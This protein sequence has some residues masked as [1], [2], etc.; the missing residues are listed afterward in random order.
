MRSACGPLHGKT[1]DRL[2]DHYLR[3]FNAGAQQ[4]TKFSDVLCANWSKPP[5][6]KPQVARLQ[7]DGAAGVSRAI[8]SPW[9]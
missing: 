9:P 3:R 6:A 5:S 4:R 2:F 1:A 7:G 8:M